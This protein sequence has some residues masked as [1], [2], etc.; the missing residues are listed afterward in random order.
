MQMWA[1]F[2]NQDIKPQQLLLPP[3]ILPPSPLFEL[4]SPFK[5]DMFNMG[6]CLKTRVL[7]LKTLI[8]DH[9]LQRDSHV[10]I[11]PHAAANTCGSHSQLSYN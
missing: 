10:S 4:S 5:D 6:G 11:P 1:T 3:E 7:L 2:R 9:S 8:V